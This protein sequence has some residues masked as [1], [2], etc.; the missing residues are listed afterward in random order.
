[1]AAAL[2]GGTVMSTPGRR[3]ALRALARAKKRNA[4]LAAKGKPVTIGGKK[5][6]ANTYKRKFGLPER[7]Q[8]RGD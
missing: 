4:N 8:K 7:L 5:I 2:K 6:S 3:R 1:M